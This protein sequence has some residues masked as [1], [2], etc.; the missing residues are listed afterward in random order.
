MHSIKPSL[1]D[2]SHTLFI[3]G[4]ALNNTTLDTEH[5]T[6]PGTD[7]H[8]VLPLFINMITARADSPRYRF[9]NHS[10]PPQTRRKGELTLQLIIA[11]LNLDLNQ[12]DL[13]RLCTF[14]SFTLTHTLLPTLLSQTITP[15]SLN[16]PV[17][18]QRI[19]PRKVQLP[20][21]PLLSLLG[22]ERR[23]QILAGHWTV[24]ALVALVLLTM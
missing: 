6:D 5:L 19:T 1:P 14:L 13:V 3:R 11:L 18:V 17:F 4:P 2:F 21:L 9:E 10:I 12:V 23:V 15:S 16:S 24:M 20:D 22:F 7:Y 8:Q